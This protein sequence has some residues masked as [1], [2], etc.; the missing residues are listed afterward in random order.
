[1]RGGSGTCWS[2]SSPCRSGS[3]C[4]ERSQRP[5]GARSGRA[6]RPRLRRPRVL[7]QIHRIP[8]RRG[9]E[10]GRLPTLLGPAQA[11]SQPPGVRPSSC[12]ALERACPPESRVDRETPAPATPRARSRVGAP[13]YRITWTAALGCSTRRVITL[14]V[15]IAGTVRSRATRQQRLVG[16]T[17]PFRTDTA[18]SAAAPKRRTRAAR[19]DSR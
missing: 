5:E 6:R 16:G 8:A 2:R 4:W 1:M 3:V 13:F 14:N 18:F 7:E 12:S 10:H 9:C 19:R 11:G 15:K 17:P